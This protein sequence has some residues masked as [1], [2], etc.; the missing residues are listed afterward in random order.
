[1][2]KGT[3]FQRYRQKKSRPDRSVKTQ[4]F[5]FHS[6]LVAQEGMTD[7][8]KNSAGDM[9]WYEKKDADLED[10]GKKQ[11]DRSCM[12][13]HS[14]TDVFLG[15]QEPIWSTK[16]ANAAEEDRVLSICGICVSKR[17]KEQLSLHLEAEDAET[18][19]EWMESIT[20]L[21]KQVGRDLEDDTKQSDAAQAQAA[22]AT[23]PA[24]GGPKKK[25]MSVVAPAKVDPK[26]DPFDLL[27]MA[28]SLPS[29]QSAYDNLDNF[30]PESRPENP[31]AED[32]WDP[33]DG[34]DPA[35]TFEEFDPTLDPFAD[36][37]FE[38]SEAPPADPSNPFGAVDDPFADAGFEEKAAEAPTQSM[39][40]SLTKLEG[41]IKK[42]LES[43]GLVELA[44]VF[45]AESV[46]LD[47]LR[48]FSVEDLKDMG[49]KAGPRVKILKTLPA[50]K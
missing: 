39:Q 27:G 6:R 46:D 15:K 41:G 21:L 38:A 13:I 8:T 19:Q 36:A 20:H 40:A 5:V 9:F 29:G 47:T 10:D 3:L 14:I 12:P 34:V 31:F 11:R 45:E 37:G 49:I 7:S 17:G 23:K 4:V 48:M 50:Y 26:A 18:A 28:E 16:C 24:E 43:V 33:F 2:A 30:F 22:Q 25:R 32:K 42:Y 1:M 35:G 44:P